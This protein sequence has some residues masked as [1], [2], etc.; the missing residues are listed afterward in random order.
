MLKKSQFL[1]AM[2]EHTTDKIYDIATKE[3]VA[4]LVNFPTVF[5]ILGF[6]SKS[7]LVEQNKSNIQLRE[8]AQVLDQQCGGDTHLETVSMM[9]SW[10]LFGYH[11]LMRNRTNVFHKIEKV[12]S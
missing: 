5:N 9:N 8:R 10:H 1:E 7:E 4:K 3:R 6:G 2:F 11:L 12:T